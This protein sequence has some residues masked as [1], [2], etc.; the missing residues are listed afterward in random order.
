VAVYPQTYEHFSGC[1]SAEFDLLVSLLVSRRFP[2]GV[3][4]EFH[5]GLSCMIPFT[6]R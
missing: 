2:M 4:V 6:W 5:S 1:R 3:G